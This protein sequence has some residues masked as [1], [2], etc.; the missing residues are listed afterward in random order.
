MVYIESVENLQELSVLTELSASTMSLIETLAEAKRVC[1]TRYR[2]VS[3]IT[4]SEQIQ[5]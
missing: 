3:I 1:A 4:L 2:L 5:A